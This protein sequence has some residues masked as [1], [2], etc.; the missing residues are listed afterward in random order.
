M[1]TFV[2]FKLEPVLVRHS[3]LL[4][5]TQQPLLSWAL[6][7]RRPLHTHAYGVLRPYGV[8]P[9][10]VSVND[11]KWWRGRRRVSFIRLDH[12]GRLELDK[13]HQVRGV[14]C[15][16]ETTWPPSTNAAIRKSQHLAYLGRV[17]VVLE[18]FWSTYMIVIKQMFAIALFV[19]PIEYGSIVIGEL[20]SE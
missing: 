19:L 16:M 2:V 5:T 8:R 15:L 3:S 1:F 4:T 18:V 17:G 11:R 10:V 9:G 14:G 13:G 12:L 6:Y 7:V 20:V